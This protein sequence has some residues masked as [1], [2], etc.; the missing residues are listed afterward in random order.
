MV[1]I[2]GFGMRR[3]A[4]CSVANATYM[5]T[6]C[7]FNFNSSSFWVIYKSNFITAPDMDLT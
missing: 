2:S 6:K 1:L 5:L 4:Q 3:F 7:I